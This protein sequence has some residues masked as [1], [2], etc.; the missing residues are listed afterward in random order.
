MWVH[1]GC[2][3]VS[4]TVLSAADPLGSVGRR[5]TVSEWG[6]FQKKGFKGGGLDFFMLIELFSTLFF[7][8]AI[9]LFQ[10]TWSFIIKRKY[11]LICHSDKSKNS[12]CISAILLSFSVNS[13]QVIPLIQ[14]RYNTKYVPL[15]RHK[16]T[17]KKQFHPHFCTQMGII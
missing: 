15:Y 8:F 4:G 9:W 13:C 5:P 16:E 3:V 10:I 17:S 1:C 12:C 11:E 14:K 2:S 6:L 7:F